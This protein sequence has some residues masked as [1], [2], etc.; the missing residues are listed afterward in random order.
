ML[1]NEREKIFKHTFVLIFNSICKRFFSDHM[2]TIEEE[3]K[4]DYFAQNNK[5]IIIT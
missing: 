2:N 1:N 4:Y 3:K 5:K